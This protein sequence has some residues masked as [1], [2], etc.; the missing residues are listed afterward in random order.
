MVFYLGGA[1][2]LRGY[3]DFAFAGNNILLANLELRYPFIEQ[4]VMRGPIPLVL[5]DLRGVFFFDIGGAWNGDIN[6]LRVARVIDG[7]EQLSG[8]NA[9]YG[10][11]IRMWLAYFLMKLDFAWATQ[12]DGSEGRRVHFSL[13]GEF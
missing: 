9:G 13:G 4:L 10:F 7:R 3:E 8:L 11:G 12:F 6:T 5:G 1:S 2:T